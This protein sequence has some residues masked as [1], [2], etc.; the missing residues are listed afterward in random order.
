LNAEEHIAIKLKAFNTN[1]QPA[2]YV[3][4]AALGKELKVAV[5]IPQMDEI[6]K[7]SRIGQ[8]LN[9]VVKLCHQNGLV[10]SAKEID[11]IIKQLT[12]MLP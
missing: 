9:Q 4:E 6:R 3:R 10:E 8:N 7:F 12:Q 2:V 5:T 1:L 11:S